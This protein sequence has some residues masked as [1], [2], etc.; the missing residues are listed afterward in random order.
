L[1]HFG[2]LSIFSLGSTRSPKRARAASGPPTSE[3]AMRGIILWLLGLPIPIII[4]LYL[5]DVI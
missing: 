3:D 2:A 5:F 1:P 4:A